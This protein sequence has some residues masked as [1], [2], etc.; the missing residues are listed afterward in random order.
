MIDEKFEQD[1]VHMRRRIRLLLVQ[2]RALMA[3]TAG[4]G[5][6]MVL[7][8]VSKWRYELGE[9][10][11]LAGII[12]FALIAGVVW[13]FLYKLNHFVTARATESRLDLKERLSSAVALADQDSEMIR[14][15]IDDASR[16]MN[17]INPKEVFP[18]RFT[19]EM[20][21]FGLMLVILFGTYFIPQIP[22]LQSKDRREEVKVMKN[23]GKRLEKLA[24]NLEERVSPDNEIAKQIAE[25]MK[26]LGKKLQ[27]GRMTRKQAILEMRKLDKDIKDAQDRIAARNQ[28]PKSMAEAGQ[29]LQNL[30]A[31]FAGKLQEQVEKELKEKLASGIKDPKLEELQ[32]RLKD[33]QESKGELTPEQIKQMEKK[34]QDY[35]KSQQNI[36]V[37]PELSALMAELIKNEDFTKAQELL[38]EL[39]KKLNQQGSKMSQEDL[40]N[41]EKQLK[42]LAEALKDT[43]LDQLSK[44]LRE[45]AEQLA[46]MD[47]EEAAERLKQMQA[48]FNMA[49]DLKELKEAGGG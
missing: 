6:A 39:S 10:I 3:G 49:K 15:L 9:P 23:E 11:L 33:L 21:A 43:D 18:Y 19:K 42:A 36:S 45:A 20:A 17:G 41:L 38:S 2:K 5:I 14:S 4:A 40:K 32:K 31:A 1:L 37:P 48:A 35:L 12:F 13:G 25:N 44:T 29:E 28:S 27:S 16:H 30:S 22:A 24:K 7:L 8:I 46:K 26:K 47:P 34:V